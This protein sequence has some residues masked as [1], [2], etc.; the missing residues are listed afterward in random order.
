[1]VLSLVSYHY[2]L[3]ESKGRKENMLY[4]I[5]IGSFEG[6]DYT[7]GQHYA[8]SGNEK[9]ESR[10]C[11][12]CNFYFFC[13]VNFQYEER[14]CNG[15]YHFLQYEKVNPNMLFRVVAIKKGTFRTV[16]ECFFVEIEELLNK[17]S[18]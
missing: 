10:Q 13:K 4:Y 2:F 12:S 16:C 18:L 6:V 15:C 8:E 14:V 1:M 5:K 17:R 3:K 11:M 7:K 9:K